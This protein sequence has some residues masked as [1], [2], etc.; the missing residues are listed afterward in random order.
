MPPLAWAYFM[1]V[2]AFATTSLAASV[3]ARSSGFIPLAA[4]VSLKACCGA[5]LVFYELENGHRL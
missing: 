5:V 1:I 4:A 2:S 3:K